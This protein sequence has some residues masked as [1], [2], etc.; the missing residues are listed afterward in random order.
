VKVT[1]PVGVAV[2]LPLPVP[3]PVPPPVLLTV[4]VRVTPWPNVEG[5]KD[6]ETKVEVAAGLTVC[7]IEPELL[8][9]LP[10]ASVKVAFT[11]CD[12]L[13]LREE[14][15]YVAQ[16][17]E[18]GALEGQLAAVPAT[19]EPLSMVKLTVP[20]GVA[21]PPPLPLPPPPLLTAAVKV[22]LCP[23]TDGFEDEE[24]KV[25]VAAGLT[26][27]AI[28]AELLLKL[29]AASVNVAFTVCDELTLREKMVYVAQ[30]LEAGAL[31]G[32]L[33]AVPATAEPLS[34]VKLTVPVGVAVLP[35]LPVPPP[36]LLTMAVKVTLWPKTDGFEDEEIVV[37]VIAGLTVSWAVP[38]LAV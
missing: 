27:C 31:E 25:E 34:M 23:Y 13:A 14:M 37:D 17:L 8:L 6:E 38:L 16:K 9:K 15:V 2:L 12:E 1:V 30:K 33:A 22:K 3:V 19:A 29:P 36:P 7:A 28:E 18:A 4:A 32:Q 5:F 35:P 26:A 21:V 24:T 20:V 10:A 11:V